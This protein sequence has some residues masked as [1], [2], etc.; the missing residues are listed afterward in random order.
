MEIRVDFPG[1][2]R[3]DAHFGSYT[4]STDQPSDQGGDGSAP[5]PFELFLASLATCAGVYV[6]GFCKRRG[7]SSE[8]IRLVQKTERDPETHM[9]ATVS[10]EIQLPAG[11]PE[12]Y[13]SAVIRAAETCLV[14]KHLEKPPVFQVTTSVG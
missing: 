4:V 1:G 10:L 5:T 13:V 3:V 8:G 9:A 6:Q 14:K 12:Q 2:A 11:F 7:I